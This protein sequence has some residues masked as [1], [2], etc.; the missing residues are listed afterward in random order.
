MSAG[1]PRRA[2]A[3]V[4]G[5]CFP[6]PG[7]GGWGVVLVTGDDRR[8][9]WDGKENSTNQR[10]EIQAA[11]TALEALDAPTKIEIVSDS[12]YLTNCGS[13]KWKRKTNRDLWERLDA[14]AAPHQVEYRWIRGHAGNPGNERAHVLAMLAI[15]RGVS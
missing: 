4:D 11:I 13:G 14:A 3:H 15:R 2:V 12:M 10:A 8:E 9:L 6:N 1:E 5:G 7:R